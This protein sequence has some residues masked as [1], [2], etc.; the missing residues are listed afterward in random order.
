M[1]WALVLTVQARYLVSIFARNG[2][3][4]SRYKCIV[5]LLLGG[6]YCIKSFDH[7]SFVILNVEI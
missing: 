3:K 1:L 4:Q 7:H 6:M 2:G 5:Y